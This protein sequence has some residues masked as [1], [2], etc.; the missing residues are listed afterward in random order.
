MLF[1][2][3]F[4]LVIVFLVLRNIAEKQGE[5]LIKKDGI[6]YYKN[7][8]VI[9]NNGK[10][11]EVKWTPDYK[12]IVY[13]IL[14]VEENKID[15]T[16]QKNKKEYKRLLE[17]RDIVILLV[18]ICD[19]DISIYKSKLKEVNKYITITEESTLFVEYHVLFKKYKNILENTYNQ[20]C[21]LK[22]QHLQ[23]IKEIFTGYELEEAEA[24]NDILMINQNEK[25][26]DMK[27][28]IEVMYK[29]YKEFKEEYVTISKEIDN[30]AEKIIE[31]T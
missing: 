9:Y 25:Y 15:G 12:N 1:L 5:N 26:T 6:A 17:I 20:V 28:N 14:Q 19:V 3:I 27:K 22:E 23:Y 29:Q 13:D 10:I 2:I 7:E 21:Q 18:D 8:Y 11:I 30:R 4:I 31:K 24:K 16:Y